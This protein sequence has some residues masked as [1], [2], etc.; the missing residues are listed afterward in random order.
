MLIQIILSTSTLV[1]GFIIYILKLGGSDQEVSEGT[2][3]SNSTVKSMSVEDYY[4]SHQSNSKSTSMDS[5]NWMDINPATN[6]DEITLAPGIDPQTGTTNRLHS[7]S[8]PNFNISVSDLD[9]PLQPH[10]EIKVL[11]KSSSTKSHETLIPNSNSDNSIVHM[12]ETADHVKRSKSTGHLKQ[13]ITV[14]K[15]QQQWKSISVEKNFLENINENLLPSVL[16]KGESPILALKR[17]Q[18]SQDFDIEQ[19]DFEYQYQPKKVNFFTSTNMGSK[20]EE[21]FDSNDDKRS[22]D[23]PYISEFGEGHSEEPAMMFEDFDQN[24]RLEYERTI[25]DFQIPQTYEGS[26]MSSTQSMRHISLDQW[27]QNS[28]IYKNLRTRSGVSLNIPQVFSEHIL[29][30]SN[31]TLTSDGEDLLALPDNRTDNIDHLSDIQSNTRSFEID[32]N[33]DQ[34]VDSEVIHHEVFINNHL[35][36]LFSQSNRSFSAPSLQTFRNVSAGS[37]SSQGTEYSVTAIC[38]FTTPPPIDLGVSE[39]PKSSPIRKLYSSPKKLF[40]KSMDTI[41]TS[42]HNYHK[43]TGSVISNQFSLYSSSSK[44]G[45]PKRTSLSRTSSRTKP[46]RSRSVSPKKSFKSLIRRSSTQS[47]SPVKVTV[48]PPT[49]LKQAIVKKQQTEIDFVE[50]RWELRPMPSV[51]NSRNSSLPSAVIGEYDR[52]KWNTLKVLNNV[53]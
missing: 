19:V 33:M 14:N 21:V 26:W 35:S 4:K 27:N 46:S 49:L 1:T 37:S 16:K 8:M 23:L 24:S 45:S 31:V 18:Q 22:A 30:D 3:S 6:A 20:T 51:S 53:S 11:P 13:T 32:Q 25:A 41:D 10:D 36:P 9:L 12:I 52:E 48:A 50:D 5:K 42:S 40:G 44:S 34:L 38:R 47:E 29:N 28:H 2:G 7:K 15:R 43:H 17:K 39:P